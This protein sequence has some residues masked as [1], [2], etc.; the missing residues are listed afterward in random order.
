MALR[1]KAKYC[2]LTMVLFAAAAA[3]QSVGADAVEKRLARDRP[4]RLVFGADALEFQPFKGEARRW[5][6]LEMQRLE[7]T[8]EGEVRLT[9]YKDVRWQAERDE[10]HRFQTK[11]L[12]DGAG[13]ARTLRQR[14]GERFVARMP[15][16]HGAALWRGGAKLLRG[17]GGPEGD[18]VLEATGWRFESPERGQSISLEDRL[19]ANVSSTGDLQLSVAARDGLGNYEFQLKSPLPRMVYEAWWQRLNLPRGLELIEV[20][21]E[22][23]R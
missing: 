10:R 4:G 22:Q 13:L 19:T 9:L 15:L 8:S 3:A 5:P 21:K 23:T 6:Y 20:T 16:E 12:T 2:S 17:W 11:G 18:F 14:M 7:L 1:S